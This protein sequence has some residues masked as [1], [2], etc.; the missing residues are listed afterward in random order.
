M[1]LQ[2]TRSAVGL[3]NATLEREKPE[4][5]NSSRS[6]WWD[7]YCSKELSH[8]RLRDEICPRLLRVSTVAN[9]QEVWRLWVQDLLNIICNMWKPAT[10]KVTINYLNWLTSSIDLNKGKA[11]G[12]NPFLIN[13]TLSCSNCIVRNKLYIHTY[14]IM[15]LKP[16]FQ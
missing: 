10:Y 1:N 5:K 4:K 12:P 16:W 9:D 11:G 3:C 8:K 14:F 2:T 7:H 15:I 13:I 6:G